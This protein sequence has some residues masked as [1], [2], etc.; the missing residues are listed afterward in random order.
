MRKELIA[1]GAYRLKL[2]VTPPQPEPKPVAITNR[3]ILPETAFAFLQ[4][5][6]QETE[7]L[8][9][10]TKNLPMHEQISALEPLALEQLCREGMTAIGLCAFADADDKEAIDVAKEMFNEAQELARGL[11]YVL[12]CQPCNNE[13]NRKLVPMKL[14]QGN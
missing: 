5:A 11:G 8:I 12:V 7:A 9:A 3:P 13:G 4:A 14:V 2:S 6:N 1:V 10:A